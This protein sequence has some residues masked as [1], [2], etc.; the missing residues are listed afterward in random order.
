MLKIHGVNYADCIHFHVGGK[1]LEQ[2]GAATQVHL[3][4]S[5]QLQSHSGRSS[6]NS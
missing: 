1:Q 6:S 3:T 2:D 4:P 5:E